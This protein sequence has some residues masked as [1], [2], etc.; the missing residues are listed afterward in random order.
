MQT[1]EERL[2]RDLQHGAS[3]IWSDVDFHRTA[4]VMQLGIGLHKTCSIV[5]C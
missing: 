3:K 5:G 4:K 1:T 2:T